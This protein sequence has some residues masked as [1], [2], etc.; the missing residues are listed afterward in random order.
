[1]PLDSVAQAQNI[2]HTYSSMQPSSSA[3]GNQD[4][5]FAS[6]LQQS[7][8]SGAIDLQAAS[9]QGSA[10]NIIKE[11][12]AS[13]EEK[14][15]ATDAADE[16]AQ[17]SPA[18]D[19]GIH[20]LEAQHDATAGQGGGQ[21]NADTDDA[22]AASATNATAQQ[23]ASL[24]SGYSNT[25]DAYSTGNT[26]TTSLLTN[27][28]SNMDTSSAS[29][30][31]GIVLMLLMLMLYSGSSSSSGT[32]F[33]S[34]GLSSS[35]NSSTD[36]LGGSNAASQATLA[37]TMALTKAYS[38][39]NN[40]LS[41]VS[42]TNN[43][44]S[45]TVAENGSRLLAQTTAAQGYDYSFMD[46]DYDEASTAA[47]VGNN[48]SPGKSFAA[49]VQ[50]DLTNRS[51]ALYRDVIEQFDVE[52]NYRYAVNKKGT[53]DTYC[54][55]FL[56]DV[57]RAMNAEIPHHTDWDTGAPLESGGKSMNA[58]RISEW[59]NTYGPQ[60]GWYEVTAEQA[61]QLAN[62]GSPAV[63]VWKNANGGHGH[64]QVVSPSSSGGYDAEKGAAIAQAGRRLKEYAYVSDIYSSSTMEHVQYFAHR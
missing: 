20:A 4:G 45:G 39:K 38:N 29:S 16:Q 48:V 13:K 2:L 27:L 47:P 30:S 42:G 57:T 3:V 51:P 62:R 26:L 56:W 35:A 1:M 8:Q 60:Y 55:I 46:D 28:M 21:S 15:S 61:Q 12:A 53:G 37:A 52:R 63:T 17:S 44:R 43:M 54:N 6:M 58:N 9:Y 40:S 10:N 33:F 25:Y 18:I 36:F 19:T 22:A 5:L 24:S 31:S 23:A 49:P 32:D 50:S 59:L 64:V 14:E 34:S 7:M 41:G 11:S